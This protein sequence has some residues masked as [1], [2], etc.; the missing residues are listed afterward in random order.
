MVFK[1]I[2]F[3]PIPKDIR[4][5]IDLLADLF[6]RDSNI[7]FSYLF[8]GLLKNRLSPLSDVDLSIYIKDPSKLDYLEMFSKIAKTLD[9]DEIDLVVLNYAPL[10][11]AG[12]ILQNRR[13]LTDK[14]P[15]FR[16]RYESLVSR[17]FF[18]FQ[19]KE[20]DILKRRYGIG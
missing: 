4:R 6:N 20:R 13:I 12:R 3:K 1:M 2:R 9:T 5:R 15:F 17:K 11:L 18:E 16:H 8:G 19:I 10:P 7:I 14:N